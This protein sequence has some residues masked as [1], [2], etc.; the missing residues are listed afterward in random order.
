MLDELI[1]TYNEAVTDTDRDRALFAIRRGLDQGLAPE[2]IVFGVVVP[3][4][5]KMLDRL[6]DGSGVSLA[7]H[8][9]ASQ[10]AAEVVDDMVPRFSQSPKTMG[11][12]VIGTAPG[13][14]HNLGKKIVIG[15]LRAQ[16]IEVFDLGMNVSAE[17]FVEEAVKHEAGVIGV[18]AMMVHTARGPGGAIRVRELLREQALEGR[19]RLAV[20]GAPY[21]FDPNLYKVVGAD[22]YGDSGLAAGR[23]MLELLEEVTGS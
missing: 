22:A 12:V 5:D 4:L 17:R 14:F 8:Y 21:R 16:M 1:R 11:R 20:G 6:T 15:C 10:I 7:Q 2:E 3:A 9:M 18:S 13:D 23:V 19:I